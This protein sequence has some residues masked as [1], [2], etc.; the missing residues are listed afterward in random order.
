MPNEF[1][2]RL[3]DFTTI[4]TAP[5]EVIAQRYVIYHLYQ[6]KQFPSAREVV[7]VTGLRFPI[8]RAKQLLSYV[9]LR[10]R[11]MFAEDRPVPRLLVETWV[12]F[13]GRRLRVQICLTYI[14][15]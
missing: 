4:F 14:F 15:V 2:E 3:A 12:I 6:E 7:E 9:A 11:S 5:E 1:R 8:K 10:L 13:S